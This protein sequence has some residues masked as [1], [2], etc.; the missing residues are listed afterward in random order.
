MSEMKN[1][2]LKNVLFDLT[3]IPNIIGALRPV[4][5]PPGI[6]RLIMNYYDLKKAEILEQ[7][8]IFI[9]P[10]EE[11]VEVKKAI[12][13][14]EII[15]KAFKT[16]VAFLFQILKPHQQKVFISHRINFVSLNGEIFLPDALIVVRKAKKEEG[17]AP[18]QLS[19]WAK[20]AIIGQLNTRDLNHKTISE[21]AEL[22]NIS[23]MHASR[24]V[25]E[26]KMAKLIKIQQ[27]GVSKHLQFAPNPELWA[28]ANPFLHSPVAR[29]IYTNTLFN[30]GKIAGLNALD[31]Y[32]MLDGGSIPTKAIGKKQFAILQSKNVIEVVPKEI[33]K[34]CVEIWEWDPELLSKKSYVDPVSLYLSLKDDMDDRTQIAL[35]QIL[36]DIV[37]VK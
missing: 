22:F 20:L 17:E 10:K 1:T 21:L 14:A 33:A 31:E 24:F 34:C 36:S 9:I 32:S 12:T 8:F 37:G 13:H 18:V 2:N 30:S 16:P 19:Q 5:I 35:K 11:D 28:Q 15:K 6:P 4:I 27:D 25:E 29:R 3:G 26:L 7:A 23:K